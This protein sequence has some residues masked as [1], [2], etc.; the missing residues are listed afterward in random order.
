[1]RSAEFGA[2][3]A[4]CPHRARKAG[5]QTAPSARFGGGVPATPPP[6][7][8]PSAPRIV[9]FPPFLCY[10]SAER[11]PFCRSPLLRSTLLMSF[12]EIPG[13]Y[14][15][16]SHSHVK[17]RGRFTRSILSLLT[18]RHPHHACRRA[19]L[20][21]Q[22]SHCWQGTLCSVPPQPSLSHLL[23]AVAAIAFRSFL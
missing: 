8:P 7:P 3:E 1:M 16:I 17:T 2:G 19:A 12:S 4:E 10:L 22:L 15:N 20:R 18:P 11:K 13:L 21:A 23:V 6:L 5:G 9:G 14:G